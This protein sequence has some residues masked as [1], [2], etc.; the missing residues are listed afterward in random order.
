M[1]ILDIEK[2]M[3][4]TKIAL[5]NAGC[6]F[7]VTN[8]GKTINYQNYNGYDGLI[9]ASEKRINV[10]AFIPNTPSHTSIIGIHEADYAEYSVF[11][12]T[13]DNC[14]SLFVRPQDNKARL[15]FGEYHNNGNKYQI[16]YQLKTGNRTP[17]TRLD[18][19][20]FY[21]LNA[22]KKDEYRIEM[23]KKYTSEYMNEKQQQAEK[24]FNALAKA[25]PVPCVCE[26]AFFTFEH[27]K[28]AD[29]KIELKI[30]K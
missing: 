10:Q 1:K 25:V 28:K 17:S 19:E 26:R 22:E 9:T 13:K 20:W 21:K 30:G 2:Q 27:I 15:A 5:A 12:M 29:G 6:K 16:D 7:T 14:T 18:E 4:R 11:K 23:P 24:T 3:E 8:S